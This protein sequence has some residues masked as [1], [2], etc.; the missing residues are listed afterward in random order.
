MIEKHRSELASEA[1]QG[2]LGSSE[3]V[4][5]LFNVLRRRVEAVSDLISRFVSVNRDRTPDEA[6]SATDRN[7]YVTADVVKAMPRGTGEKV[8]VVFFKVSRDISDDDLEKEYA[9]RGLVPADA[10]SLAAVNEADPS[11]ADD[12]PNATHWKDEND[13]WCYAAFDRWDDGRSVDVGRSGYDWG[14]DWW[15]AGLRPSST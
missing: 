10:Y 1:T 13:K 7:K 4:D 11:F 15:F 14:D 8:E 6:L 3:Y 9:L 12:R 2:V 5:E